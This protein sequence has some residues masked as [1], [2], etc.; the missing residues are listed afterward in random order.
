MK[1][2]ISATRLHFSQHIL[3]P[4]GRTFC[5]KRHGTGLSGLCSV[6]GDRREVSPA[7]PGVR[8]GLGTGPGSSSVQR[9]KEPPPEVALGAPGKGRG[10]GGVTLNAVRAAAAVCLFLN[11]VA[12]GRNP[13]LKFL[14]F[15]RSPSHRRTPA[16]V[17]G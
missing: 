3:P 14:L 10:G 1:R 5:G 17:R 4:Q 16:A 2:N 13:P 15:P 8:Q 12:P 9:A 11:Q 6:P 7:R